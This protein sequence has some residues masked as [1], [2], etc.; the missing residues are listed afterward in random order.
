MWPKCAAGVLRYFAY[1]KEEFDIPGHELARRT[2]PAPP[3]KTV[4]PNG[5]KFPA[6]S[7]YIAA[8]VRERSRRFRLITY[9]YHTIRN[10]KGTYRRHAIRIIPI[11]N[12]KISKPLPSGGIKPGILQTGTLRGPIVGYLQILPIRI[13]S[14]NQKHN[15]KITY[16]RDDGAI[17]CRTYQPH[18]K[19]RRAYVN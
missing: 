15:P 16:K 1:F 17:K 2:R 9:Q 18:N 7:V 10:E 13:N 5:A 14:K 19:S 6:T 8:R 11:R 12:S 3:G 4:P